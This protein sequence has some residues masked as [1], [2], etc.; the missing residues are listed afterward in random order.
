MSDLIVVDEFYESMGAFFE[1]E[2]KYLER[3]AKEYALIMHVIKMNGICE[4]ETAEALDAYIDL[5]KQID[6]CA[7]KLGKCVKTLMRTYK[8]AIDA[9]DKYIF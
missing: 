9:K 8:E 4:G 7:S 2:G 5:A 3:I 6:D 1:K